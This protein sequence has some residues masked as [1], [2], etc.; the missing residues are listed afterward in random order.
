MWPGEMEKPDF[1]HTAVIGDGE[2]SLAI[3]KA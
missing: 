1:E 2:V 3:R